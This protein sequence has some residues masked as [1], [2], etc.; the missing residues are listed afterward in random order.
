MKNRI[1]IS[2]LVIAL[3]FGLILISNSNANEIA[4]TRIT[5]QAGATLQEWVNSDQF[6]S[7][8]C[9]AGSERSEGTDANWTAESND[10]KW[11]VYCFEQRFINPINYPTV[12]TP[13]ATTVVDVGQTTSET[14][15]TQSASTITVPLS[16]TQTAVMSIETI[17]ISETQTA[18]SSSELT[19]NWL[20]EIRKLL[21]YLL[22]LISK[23]SKL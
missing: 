14:Q 10:D 8:S 17:T 19:Q 22:A 16:E 1:F 12:D 2:A 23:L 4:G 20:I 6:K 13:T 18:V 15:T 7:F 11:F 5:S 3:F 9:P 21:D